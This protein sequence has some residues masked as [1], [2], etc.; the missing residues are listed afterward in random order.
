MELLEFA[1]GPALTFAFTVF[2]AGVAFRIFS[3]LLLWRSRDSSAGRPRQRPVAI[4]ALREIVRRMWPEAVYQQRM[5]FTLINGYVFHIG[6]ALCVFLLLPHI[7]FFEDLLGL[8]WP[9]L[10]NNVIYAV[11]VVTLVSLIAALV[12]R[13]AN[14]VQRIISTADD[15]FSWLVTFLPVLS[16]LVA[17]SHLGA[18]YETL[19]ALHI[20]SVALLL[21][22]LPFGKLMHAFLVFVTRS[23][24]GA[25]LNRRGAQL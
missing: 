21:V 9:H 13:V 19:L 10:P 2:I 4:A 6:L 12:M 8:S 5:L 11:S 25:Q 1:R 20:L 24:T 16:G 15:Y 18:R 14:P 7:L 22:W 3:L 17:T 23:Q